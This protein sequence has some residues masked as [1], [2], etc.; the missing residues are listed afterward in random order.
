MLEHYLLIGTSD[1]YQVAKDV[2]A[3]RY[4]NS[5]V[6]DTAF[7]SK[8]E[9][10]SRISPRD[11]TALREFLDFFD[12]IRAARPTVLSLGVL[13]YSKEN[14]QL[15]DK[16]CQNKKTCTACSGARLTCLHRTRD[17]ELYEGTSNCMNVFF[18]LGQDCGKDHSMIIPVWVRPEGDPSKEYLEYAVLDDQSNVGF[19]SESLC[20][21][22][23]LLNLLNSAATFM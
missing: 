23:N 10:W 7:T 6:I 1:A 18:L 4:E 16:N 3:E 19:V 13:D 11:A 21:R 17:E 12:K 15:V 20:D 2:L 9:R 5:S 8:L 22:L 14:T